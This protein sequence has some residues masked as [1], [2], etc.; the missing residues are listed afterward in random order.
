MKQ[1]KVYYKYTEVA[2]F[3]TMKEAKEY[4]IEQLNNDKELDI[5]DFTI[6]GLIG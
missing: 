5:M 6:Y 2:E 3:N 4:I 1:Y